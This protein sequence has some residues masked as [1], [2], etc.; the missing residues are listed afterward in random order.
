MVKKAVIYARYS[1]DS[2]TEQSIEGQLR[3]CKEY[4]KNNDILIVDTYIDRAMTGTNDMRPDFQRMLKDSA[5]QQWEIVL[6]YKLD[7]FSRDKYETT[8][9]KHTL[10]ENGVKLVSAMENI[11]D[12]PE[13]IILESLL[14][15]MNQYYSAELSQKINRGLKESWMKGQTTGGPPV[16]GYDVIDKKC[17]INEYESGI[18]REAFTKY[19][20]GYKATAIVNEFKEK[21][22]RRKNGKPIEDKYLYSLL[23]DKR[24]TGVV[25]HQGVVYD[26]I[27][28]RIISDELWNAVSAINDENKIAPSRK[29]EIFDFILSGKL[30]CGDC[31]HRM[32]GISG[33]SK[34]GAIHYYYACQ[35]KQRRKMKCTTKPIQKQFLEDMVINTTAEMLKS[36]SA[37]H[38]MAE[39][40]YNVHKIETADN[41]ALKLLERKQKDTLKAQYNMIKAIEQGIIT[42][43]TKNRL[44]EL[45][46][47]L[48]S[49][50]FE[51]AKEKA[52]SYTY[53][54]V[55][56]IELYLSKFVFENTE[57]IKVRKLIVNTFV[58]E[59]I[60][61]ED[62]IVITYTFTDEPEH[63]KRNKETTLK[64]EKQIELAEKSASSYIVSS[65][66][67]SQ[68]PPLLN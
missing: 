48:T 38:K 37:I 43:A 66:I 20:Q 24:Y 59:V 15:G 1:S 67:F 65:S 13:G 53:L 58:R 12:S 36:V 51:I 46:K 8:I 62:E 9:H 3:V 41:T 22:Y 26:N 60:L 16:F 39:S 57:D 21:G 34:T 42:E 68:C 61:Y 17:V 23:H 55:E 52:R 63:L 29:K 14:E 31:K 6:V 19:A 2:Q 40:I 27:F 7:R 28:P 44:T 5:K 4:A 47:E 56:Q 33:T 50:E 32:I 25:E 10:K 45:E 18:I 54:T 35:S 49:L 30:I 11:P 64:T